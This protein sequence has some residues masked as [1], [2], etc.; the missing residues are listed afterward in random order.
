MA[1]TVACPGCAMQ[2]AVAPEL[3]GQVLGCPHCHSQFQV[4]APPPAGPPPGAQTSSAPAPSSFPPPSPS[5][6]PSAGAAP[7]WRGDAG[8]APAGFKLNDAAPPSPGPV[9]AAVPKFKPADPTTAIVTLA[10]DGKLPEL[11]LA[12]AMNRTKAA[13]A[14]EKKSRPF[15]LTLILGI[16]LV[17]SV[18]LS[19]ADLSP[20]DSGLDARQQA[21]TQIARFYQEAGAALE[22][23]QLLLRDAQRAHSRGDHAAERARYREVLRL[24]RAENRPVSLTNNREGDQQLEEAIA[25]VLSES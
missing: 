8:A 1:M 6:S 9:K 22:P 12:E 15:A 21:R 17:S 23:Y 11:T 3:I 24:L 25:L 19:L 7:R 5:P 14:S 2:L 13:P 10:A 20:S 18:F 4:A 16:S